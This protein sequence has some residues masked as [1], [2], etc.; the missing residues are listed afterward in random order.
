[1]RKTCELFTLMMITVSLVQAANTP[2]ARPNLYADQIVEQNV[3]AR[4]GLQAWRAVK[5]LSF[6]GKMG[7]GG[8]QRATLPTPMQDPKEFK[9]TLPRR[10]ADEAQLPFVMEM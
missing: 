10:P 5:T 6:E 8:N 9:N 7:A 4:G 1:M 3:A 2:P